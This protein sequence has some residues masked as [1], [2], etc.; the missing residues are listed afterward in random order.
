MA[1]SAH[2][3]R[4][5]TMPATAPIRPSAY[6]RREPEKEP[7]TRPSP[8]IWK[9]FFEHTRTSGH[10][11]P[12]H[13]EKEMRAF[14]EGGDM[15]YGFVRKRCE[16]RGVSRAIAFSPK[17]RGSPPRAT[18]SPLSDQDMQQIVQ[19]SARR[20]IRL[21]I[22]ELQRLFFALKTP[23]LGGLGI[24]CSCQWNCLRSCQLWATAPIS[25]PA[26]RRGSGLPM[27]GTAA[28][29]CPQTS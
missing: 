13:V 14:L 25:S 20:I 12:L 19:T 23:W 18:A 22:L 21:R 8:S 5:G 3:W 10:G 24:S 17:S 9:P 11:L 15:A 6:P 28:A 26:L 27:P 4:I 16:D 1:G 29:S 2:C 7:S